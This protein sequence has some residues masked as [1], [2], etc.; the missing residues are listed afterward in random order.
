MISPSPRC[1]LST[2]QSWPPAWWF[3]VWSLRWFWC[4][5]V[6]FI[7]LSWGPRNIASTTSSVAR[8]CLRA[9]GCRRIDRWPSISSLS[10]P[11]SRPCA[12]AVPSRRW[13]DADRR[14]PSVAIDCSC[15]PPGICLPVLYF[16]V[17]SHC[18]WHLSSQQC[19]LIPP[20]PHQSISSVP[21]RNPQ[22][23]SLFHSLLVDSDLFRVEPRWVSQ[24]LNRESYF[25]LPRMRLWRDGLRWWCTFMLTCFS[26][27]T[28]L[29][30]IA[31]IV[32]RRLWLS[33]TAVRFWPR[34]LPG[35][36]CS[37]PIS[38]WGI[39]QNCS[40]ILTLTV[41]RSIRASFQLLGFEFEINWFL[42]LRR[43]I[44]LSCISPVRS[45]A[46]ASLLRLFKLW[47]LVISFSFPTKCPVGRVRRFWASVWFRRL[48]SLLRLRLFSFSFPSYLCHKLFLDLPAFRW[49][50]SLWSR[51]GILGNSGPGAQCR[52][53][54]S[55]DFELFFECMAWSVFRWGCRRWFYS[56][57]W[58]WSASW[59][60]NKFYIVMRF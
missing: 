36:V 9:I 30:I 44:F 26:I 40:I 11:S 41:S 51:M 53:I 54:C 31:H 29:L 57:R 46:Y 1:R 10:R 52:F 32:L 21:R 24:S 13:F 8:W 45:R 17:G 7:L 34:K 47:L 3:R 20:F 19:S 55:A 49:W 39:A 16:P 50:L 6:W 18:T 25:G 27:P 14:C 33:P 28:F 42:P 56:A 2:R 38:F 5:C 12:G 58:W 60:N 4:A 22:A 48:A 59:N 43:P 15:S 35:W 37:L 23:K